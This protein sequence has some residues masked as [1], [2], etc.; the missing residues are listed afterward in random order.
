ML[1]RPA[2]PTGP[3]RATTRGQ[4]APKAKTPVFPR[5][6]LAVTNPQPTISRLRTRSSQSFHSLTV[7]NSCRYAH[8]TA[9]DRSTSKTSCAEAAMATSRTSTTYPSRS[10]AA[11]QPANWRCRASRRTA[12]HKAVLQRAVAKARWC[13]AMGRLPCALARE[14]L[15]DLKA[16]RWDAACG[17]ASESRILAEATEGGRALRQLPVPGLAVCWP[18]ATERSRHSVNPS[19]RTGVITISL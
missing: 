18:C 12:R 17:A 1:L 19:A 9:P 10:V 3:G 7:K 11:R 16:G 2:P 5:V 4:V 15:V 8:S 14:A 6:T 13:G